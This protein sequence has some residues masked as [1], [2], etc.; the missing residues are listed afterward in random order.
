[1]GLFGAL[2][3]GVSGLDSQSNKIGII[4]NNISNVNTVGFKQGQAAFDTLVVPSGT[5]SF[6]P[7][8]VIGNTQQL[9]NQ[10]GIISATTSSTDVAISGG[11]FLVVNTEASGDGNTYFTRAGSFT[12]D[13]NGNFINADGYY[14]QG[15]PI[16]ANGEP[17][18]ANTQNLKTVQISQSATGAATATTTLSVAANLDAAQTVLLGPGEVT[19]ITPNDTTNIENTGTQVLV[20]STANGLVVG[21]Q[22]TI[23]SSGSNGT[24]PPV[25]FTYGGFTYGRNITAAIG[26]AAASSVTAGISNAG[27]GGALLDQ[28]TGITT[29]L[30]TTTSNT[31]TITVAHGADYSATPGANGNYINISGVTGTVGGLPASDINGEWQ[32]TNVTG[33]NVTFQVVNSTAMTAGTGQGGNDITF[34]NRTYP[35]AGNILDATTDT[36]DFLG[37]SGTIPFASNALE[38]TITSNGVTSTYTYNSAPNTSQGQFNSL[39]TLA[40]AISNT[41]GL[42]ASVVNH[43]LYV[44]S[45]DANQAVTFNNVDA[46]GSNGLAGINWVQELGLPVDG[47]PAAAAGSHTFNSLSGLSAQINA[48]DPTN[49]ISTVNN[50]T[51]TTPT[52]AIHEANPLQ[53]IDISDATTNTGDSLVN[54]LGLTSKN[55][56]ALT[57]V[58]TNPQILTTNILPATYDFTDNTRNMSSGAVTPQYSK[59]IT[60]Y[61]AQ[62]NSH[63][64]AMNFV[65]LNTNTWAVELTAVPATDITPASLDGQVAYGTLTF[66]GNGNL[67]S[68]V[69][70]IASTNGFNINWTNGASQSNI[71]M[72]LGVDSNT[73]LIQTAGSFNFSAA[74][75]NGSPVGELTGVS[76]DNSGF[77]IASFSNGQTQKLYQVPLASVNNPDGLE[78]VSGNAYEQTLASGIAN[79]EFAGTSGVGTLTPSSLEQSNVDLS[80]QLTDLIVAQQ[81]YGANSKVLTVADTLL[82]ELDQIIQS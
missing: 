22:I 43:Q 12:Q 15:L 70:T 82:Q 58:G 68:A 35:F 3:A 64:L 67:Q 45:T 33:N 49:L 76:I 30:T 74:N 73:G 59:D 11:G 28:E 24:I 17:A 51:S 21:D 39:D 80:T 79:L 5:T 52:I 66:A 56:A 62:G 36:A 46:T 19:A 77:V 8:G 78:S 32:V 25:S 40:T 54:E 10:Q 42:T 81:A 26:Q 9:V 75:Q 38:F 48:A 50:P 57:P 31:V 55:G 7:G 71:T 41:T 60:V 4:S 44:S 37:S 13:A 23:Q 63:T 6:S 34:T 1:M 2:F 69:G 27:G 20:P 61:D 16:G 18:Q 53:T 72:T 65:K 14:L 29:G 47:I